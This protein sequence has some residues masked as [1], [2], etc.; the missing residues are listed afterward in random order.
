MDGNRQACA[1]ADRPAEARALH[2]ELSALRATM[3]E[4]AG[5]RMQRWAPMLSRPEFHTSAANMADYLALRCADLSALQPRL[6]ALGLS[7]LGRAEAHVRASIDAVLASLALIGNLG[8]ESHPAPEV[9]VA[10]RALL[11]ARRDAL[12]GAR[13]DAPATRIMVTLPSDAA[14]GSVLPRLV[15]AGADCLRINCAHDDATVWSALAVTGRAEAAR[16]GRGVVVQMDLGGPKLRL[17]EVRERGAARLHPGDSFVLAAALAKGEKRAQATLSHPDVLAR[18]AAGTPVWINDGKL[19]AVVTELAP[20]RVVL[21]V[22]ATRAKGEHLKPEK[23]VNLPGL[24]LEIPALTDADRAALDVVLAEADLIGFSFVQ[25]V[26]DVEALIA[27]IDERRGARPLPGLVLKVETPLALRNLPDLIVAAGGRMPVAV[28][29]ARGDLAVEAGFERMAEVQ[30]EL[31]W[32]CEAAQVPV[33][34]ATQVLEGLVKDG[35]VSR[36]EA[37]DAAM[38]QRAE[39]VML[40]KGPHLAEGVAFLRGVLE[41]M[42][43]HQD[44]KSAQMGALALWRPTAP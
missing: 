35:A 26:A 41:R 4:D 5:R 42:D 3:T 30:E 6:S 18:L 20:G 37:T 10:G 28:M 27:A 43:R 22:T 31:L 40:N 44:K 25:T 19:G 33:I 2:A 7:S 14:S 17:V 1:G 32:L 9:F 12:F 39:C 23:G 38:S 21:E 36:A 24:D 8:G 15:A 29:I 11:A 13:R 34:W 16:A